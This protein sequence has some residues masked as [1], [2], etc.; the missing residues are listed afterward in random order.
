MEQQ[1]KPAQVGR[2]ERGNALENKTSLLSSSSSLTQTDEKD[3]NGN[4]NNQA[5]APTNTGKTA[6]GKKGSKSRRMLFPMSKTRT[7]SVKF[8]DEQIPAPLTI[9]YVIEQVRGLSSELARL[10]VILCMHNRDVRDSSDD[11]W[12]PAVEKRHYHLIARGLEGYQFQ[13]L[14]MLRRLGVVFRPSIDDE[15]WKN[16]GVETVG[17]FSQY[18]LYFTHETDDALSNGSKYTYDLETMW[19]N[20]ES[21]TFDPIY[22]DGCD[23]FM[24]ANMSMQAVKEIREGYIRVNRK[25]SKLNIDQKRAIDQ[26]LFDLGYQFGNFDKWLDSQDFVVRADAK[27]RVYEESYARGAERRRIDM[28]E[29]GEVVNRVCIFIQGESGTGKSYASLGALKQKGFKVLSVD[30]GGSGKFDKL[31]PDHDAILVND[32]VLPNALN[33]CDDKICHAYRRQSNNPLW[34]GRFVVVT[35]N[36]SFT[37]WLT[38][39]HITNPEHVKAMNCRFFRCHMVE[40]G[41]LYYLEL[42]RDRTNT[43]GYA[44]PSRGNVEKIQTL[45]DEFADFQNV[46]NGISSSYVRPVM[47][48]LDLSKLNRSVGKRES[49]VD[50]YNRWFDM[51]LELVEGV[52]KNLNKPYEPNQILIHDDPCRFEEAYREGDFEFLNT[53]HYSV[54]GEMKT[55]KIRFI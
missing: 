33:L 42:D 40:R 15:L 27:R 7:M 41:G 9:Q 23:G 6:K 32:D 19:R 20:G 11:L 48:S 21:K 50:A 10:Q 36:K 39:C 35:S 55:A 18:A 53:V 30:G 3:N 28:E 8:Y 45:L 4:I 13:V 54:F 1:K 12:A 49:V 25:Y 31:K 34:A 52:R 14:A 46:F 47:G 37:D 51:A 5:L 22:L 44:I 26:E 2:P 38:D 17:N 29:K 43:T 24:V 16:K